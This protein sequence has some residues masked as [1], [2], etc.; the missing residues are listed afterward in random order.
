MKL[1]I[2]IKRLKEA[3]FI[4]NKDGFFDIELIYFPTQKEYTKG[5]MKY[6]DTVHSITNLE[7]VKLN[8]LEIN[9][10]ESK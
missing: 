1:Y 3:H 9:M 5:Y 4:T 8:G 10:E 6:C 2:D 7:K